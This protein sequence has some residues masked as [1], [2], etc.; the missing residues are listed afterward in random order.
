VRD[1]ADTGDSG[2]LCLAFGGK[3]DGV[4][5]AHGSAINR[6]VS[7]MMRFGRAIVLRDNLSG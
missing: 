5:F 4:V 3:R 2:G 6:S 7:L 1:G